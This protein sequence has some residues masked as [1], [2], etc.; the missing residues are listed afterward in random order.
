MYAPIDDAEPESNR[1]ILIDSTLGSSE[2]SFLYRS[3]EYN[4][5]YKSFDL[6]LRSDSDVPK[7]LAAGESYVN[8][9]V[10]IFSYGFYVSTFTQI[11]STPAYSFS[12]LRMKV[13]D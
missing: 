4:Q 8:C 2:E 5:K 3:I 10:F 13:S 1:V 7:D 12:T 9:A 11:Y 6:I